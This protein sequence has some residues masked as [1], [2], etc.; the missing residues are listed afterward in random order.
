MNAN[1]SKSREMNTMNIDSRFHAVLVILLGAL[2][3]GLLLVA[4][5]VATIAPASVAEASNGQCVWEGGSG[6]HDSCRV[7]DCIG[8]GGLAQCTTKGVGAVEAPH[9]DDQVGPDKWVFSQIED[10]YNPIFTNPYYCEAAGGWF[11]QLVPPYGNYSC[12][13]LPADILGG[14][15]R[16]TNSESRLFSIAKD[17]ASAWLCG[18]TAFAQS[19]TGWSLQ[20]QSLGTATRY[21]RDIVYGDTTCSQTI[22]ISFTKRRAARCAPPSTL[23]NAVTGPECYIPGCDV[24]V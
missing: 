9:T 23:R 22:P 15:G 18:G 20:A 24:C 12:H 19:D 4:A 1:T 10:Y 11:G 5:A 14:G 21:E 8:R 7:E 13:D 3:T 16:T 6:A 2:P 17:F